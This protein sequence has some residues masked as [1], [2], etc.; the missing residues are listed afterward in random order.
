MKLGFYGERAL[1][2]VGLAVKG[3]GEIKVGQE[4]YAASEV[5]TTSFFFSRFFFLY[6]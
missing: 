3:I 6:N 5:S 4:V 2:C 1:V